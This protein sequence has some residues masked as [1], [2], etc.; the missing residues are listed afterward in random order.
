LA[1]DFIQN[2]V[3]LVQILRLQTQLADYMTVS[4][5]GHFLTFVDCHFHEIRGT[6]VP[7]DSGTDIIQK[8]IIL[9]VN[10]EH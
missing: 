9:K 4:F 6:E 8:Q 10:N 3:E 5:N 1:F 2:K 7:I